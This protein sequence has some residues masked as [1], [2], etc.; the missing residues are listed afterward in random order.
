MMI[1]MRTRNA[2]NVGRMLEM[3][4]PGKRKQEKPKRFMDVVKED[5]QAGGWRE[6]IERRKLEEMK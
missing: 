6:N 1:H 4:L 5:R 3:E 2:G